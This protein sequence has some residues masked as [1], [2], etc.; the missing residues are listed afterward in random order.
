MKMWGMQSA[1]VFASA[2]G[3]VALPLAGCSTSTSAVSNTTATKVP[4]TAAPSGSTHASSLSSTP[5]TST[6]TPVTATALPAIRLAA[7]V[8]DSVSGTQLEKQ[9]RRAVRGKSAHIRHTAGAQAFQ[10]ATGVVSYGVDGTAATKLT[11]QIAGEQVN[12]VYVGDVLYLSIPSQQSGWLAI[13]PNGTDSLSKQFAPLLATMRQSMNGQTVGLSGVTWKVASVTASTVTY[14]TH[15]T[16]AMV[17]K[18]SAKVGLGKL[19]ES[20][21]T[22]QDI[23]EV[24]SAASGLPQSTEVLSGG[25]STGQMR[26]TNWGPAI[27][28]SAPANSTPA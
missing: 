19:V 22:D 24:V 3:L 28:I 18:E 2:A 5:S 11:E 13:R 12:L 16:A 8:G 21:A 15:L 17:R 26:Y 9:T 25:T 20:T 1:V 4:A 14:R 7:K 23:I 10:I 27:K 6:A